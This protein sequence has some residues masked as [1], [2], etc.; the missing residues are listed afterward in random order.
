MKGSSMKVILMVMIVALCF[1]GSAAQAA[2]VHYTLNVDG[3][4]AFTLTADVTGGYGLA[5]YNIPLVN[6]TAASDVAPSYYSPTFT[7]MGFQAQG[8]DL[9]GPGTLFSYQEADATKV[10]YGIGQT[11]GN[12]TMAVGPP[13]EGVPWAASVVLATGTYNTSGSN[14]AFG[15]PVGDITGNVLNTAD[16][17]TVD[18]ATVT[19]SVVVI[20]EPATMIVLALGAGAAMLR[21]RR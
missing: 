1:V 4:G 10:I 6:I 11:A 14:P 17:F 16:G 2:S 15:T 13:Y 7:P 20:P 8:L 18:A 19:T 3:A 9:T 21:R 5:Y 12:P